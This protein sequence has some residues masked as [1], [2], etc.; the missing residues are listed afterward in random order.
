MTVVPGVGGVRKETFSFTPADGVPPP[1]GPFAHATR[2][3]S[4][5]FVTG[6]M[7]TDR[8][9]DSPRHQTS[10]ARP[11]ISFPVSGYACYG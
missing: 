4:L 6:Q 10:F 8:S 7:P 9:L 3:G 1:V 11:A 5:V 2:W